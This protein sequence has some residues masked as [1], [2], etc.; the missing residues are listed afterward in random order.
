M[1]Q[2]YWNVGKVIVKEEQRGRAR[3][4][5]GEYLIK[6]IS[7]KLIGA[8]WKGFTITNVKYFRQFYISFLIG[9]ALRDQ[10]AVIRSELSWTHYRLLQKM[11]RPEV[12]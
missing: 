11:E 1:V 3:A 4:G 9:H 12:R 2:A 5:F 8:F 7:A 10:L 6:E